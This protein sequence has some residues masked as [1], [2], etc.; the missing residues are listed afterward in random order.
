MPAINPTALAAHYIELLNESLSNKNAINNA[1]IE[2]QILINQDPS[3]TKNKGNR[4]SLDEVAD[5]FD[6]NGNLKKNATVSYHAM[7]RVNDERNNFK[8]QPSMGEWAK[9]AL[10]A[11]YFKAGS[12]MI[13]ENSMVEAQ[14][15][16]SGKKMDTAQEK[17]EGRLFTKC[18]SAIQLIV[19]AELH[20][21]AGFKNPTGYELNDATKNKLASLQTDANRIGE[22]AMETAR[23]L[24]QWED[25]KQKLLDHRNKIAARNPGATPKDPPVFKAKEDQQKYDILT[26]GVA[27]IEGFLKDRDLGALQTK[28]QEVTA[29]E[30]KRTKGYG[31]HTVTNLIA[32]LNKEVEKLAD[33]VAPK[34][35]AAST[36]KSAFFTHQP[37]SPTLQSQSVPSREPSPSP[38]IS[39]RGP[40]SKR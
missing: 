29:T 36:N 31:S 33:S 19:A 34:T 13:M 24:V 35:Q 12:D 9:I 18:L 15:K 40:G 30:S 28:M 10:A 2:R 5:Q 37:A 26:Q 14:E 32:N 21:V 25:E 16:M 6:E 38:S 23:F 4:A 22:Q 11:A 8:L 39:N 27:A 3:N 7:T 20:Q 17:L 1:V